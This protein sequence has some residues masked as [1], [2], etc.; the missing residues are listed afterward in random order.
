MGFIS[1]HVMPLVI[2]SLGGGYTHTSMLTDVLHRV[3]LR[4]QEHTWFL[5]VTI[6]S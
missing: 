2:Y 3:S 6:F 1:Y 4:N 5:T